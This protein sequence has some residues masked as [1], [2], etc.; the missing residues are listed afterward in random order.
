M[1]TTSINRNYLLQVITVVCLLLPCFFTASAQHFDLDENRK[2]VKLHFEH[3]RN[4]VVIQMHI[5]DRGPFNFILDTGVGVMIITD[6]TLVDSLNITSKRTVKIPGLGDGG[7]AE[8]YITSPLNI[9]I[10][11]LKSYNVSAA[12]LKKDHFNLSNFVG[13]PI[14]GLLGYEFFN[15][16]AVQIDFADSTLTVCRPENIKLIKGGT[17]IPIS[18]EAKKPYINVKV[19]MPDGT[20]SMNKLIIDLGAGHPLS[21]ENVIKEKGLPQKFIAGNLGIGLNGP[22]NGFISR[23]KELDIGGFK[24]KEP[25][26][27]L[28]DGK[29]NVPLSVKR[30]GNL[31][32]GVLK[33]FKVIFNYSDNAIYLKKARGFG[34][35]FDHDMSGLEYFG[36]GEDHRPDRLLVGPASGPGDTGDRDRGIRAARLQRAA[37]HRPGHGDR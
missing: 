26:A 10:P 25:L 19:T 7:D 3:I 13:L 2:R 21:L 6:P 20:T 1:L 9:Y 27:S 22:I 17:K 23:I 4:M 31:G 33:R 5:N 28:P 11:G 32:V 36:T 15:K 24:I 12:I 29:N 18:I 16:L 35:P 14:H 30:D 37:R 8:A 34:E